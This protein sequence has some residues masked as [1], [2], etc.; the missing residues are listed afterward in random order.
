MQIPKLDREELK[1]QILRYRKGEEEAAGEILL[2]YKHIIDLVLL[3]LRYLPFDESAKRYGAIMGV[4][5]AIRN[6]NMRSH[7]GCYAYKSAL[8]YALREVSNTEHLITVPVAIRD[9]WRHSNHAPYTIC[10]L[11]GSYRW[12]PYYDKDQYYDPDIRDQLNEKLGYSC[13]VESIDRMDIFKTAIKKLT[14]IE[15][16]AILHTSG[17]S[18]M[19][20]RANGKKFNISGERFRQIEKVAIEKLRNFAKRRNLEFKEFYD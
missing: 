14:E 18:T 16:D 7:F 10:S 12:R 8:L 6:Y 11:D 3:K 13:D 5:S 15:K 17:E 9:N 20:L 1:K 4:Y 19:S 2:A